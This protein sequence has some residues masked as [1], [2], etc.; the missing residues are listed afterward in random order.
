MDI[1]NPTIKRNL[2]FVL[3]IWMLL[4]TVMVWQI[5][6]RERLHKEYL[7]EN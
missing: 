5:Y 1:S 3:A 2:V 4:L 7:A 6:K